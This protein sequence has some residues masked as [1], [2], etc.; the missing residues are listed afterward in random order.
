MQ[1]ISSEEIILDKIKK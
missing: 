1:V